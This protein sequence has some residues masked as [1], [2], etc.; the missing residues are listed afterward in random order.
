MEDKIDFIIPEKVSLLNHPILTE[1]WV[2]NKIAENPTLLGLGHEDYLIL[3]DKE[4]I[5]PKAGRLDLLLECPDCGVRYETE[6]QLGELNESHIIRTIEYWDIE[7]KRYPK[8]EHYA[9]II[10][11]DVTSRFLNVIS[12][13]NRTIPLIVIKMNAYK[14]QDNYWL[15]FTTILDETTLDLGDEDEEVK[16]V[17]D[18]NYWVEKG[19]IDTVSLADDLLNLIK[20]FDNKYE[21][22]YNKFYIGLAKNG[23]PDN[24]ASFKPRKQNIAVEMRLEQSD[25][26]GHLIEEAGFDV[27]YKWGRYRVRLTKEDFLKNGVLIKNLLKLASGRDTE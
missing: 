15:T 18:R 6:V 2:Q 16:E 11:E 4:R 25:Y 17:T 14:Y 13:L 21:L 22:K 9:V 7:R 3:R 8:Y 23:Q 1:K 24:F 27:D 10:A 19:T 26:I 5:Q 12:L 20:E